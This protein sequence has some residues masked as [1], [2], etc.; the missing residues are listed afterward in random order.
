MRLHLKKIPQGASMTRDFPYSQRLRA[1]DTSPPGD[2]LIVSSNSSSSSNPWRDTG[3]TAP[4]SCLY[5][6][7]GVAIKYCAMDTL[8]R[9]TG[10]RSRSRPKS[11]RCRS[12]LVLQVGW[13]RQRS[14]LSGGNFCARSALHREFGSGVRPS[15][16]R[17]HDL[18][19]LLDESPCGR[20]DE[21]DEW[22]CRCSIEYRPSS[23]T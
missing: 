12:N 16:R 3:R 1:V 17:F 11:G 19:C 23:N 6:G 4:L 22:D 18:G 15:P 2:S 10:T 8:N 14:R 20:R 9:R 5:W 13:I 7:S 21:Q